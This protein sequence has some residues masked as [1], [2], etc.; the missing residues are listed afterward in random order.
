MQFFLVVL[1]SNFCI[2]KNWIWLAHKSLNDEE[3]EKCE[4]EFVK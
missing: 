4:F 2:K 3:E 1:F